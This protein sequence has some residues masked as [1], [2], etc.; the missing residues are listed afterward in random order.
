MIDGQAF[1]QPTAGK[2]LAE[3]IAEVIDAGGFWTMGE[4]WTN[5]AVALRVFDPPLPDSVIHCGSVHHVYGDGPQKGQ[6]FA[7]Q[8]VWVWDRLTP[9]V[10]NKI[11]PVEDLIGRLTTSTHQPARII[12]APHDWPYAHEPECWRA[13]PAAGADGAGELMFANQ[14]RAAEAY[15]QPERWTMTPAPNFPER[16][17]L[18]G[19]QGTDVVAAIM[20]VEPDRPTRSAGAREREKVSA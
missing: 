13:E 8:D 20:P 16:L 15:A 12:R 19:W 3:A 11:S 18:L 4:W 2:P 9:K 14:I 7:R 6:V 1:A 5:G 17:M 10:P